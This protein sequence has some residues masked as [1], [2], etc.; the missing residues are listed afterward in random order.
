MTA[1]ILEH[2]ERAA[3]TWN[4]GGKHYDQISRGIADAIEHCVVR[5]N[6]RPGE[7][8]LD[9]STGTGW[10]SR[11]IARHG[12]TV[13]GVD[14]ARDLLTA[15]R[16]KANAERLP[17][18]YQLG[19]AESL[20]FEDASFDIVVSTFGVMFAERPDKA[21]EELARVCRKDGRVALTT[22]LTDGNLSRMFDVLGAYQPASPR[23][24]SPSPFE[25]GRRERIR[26]LLGGTF[27]LRFEKGV[28]YYR[29]PSPEA[30][31]ETFSKGFGPVRSL[32]ASLSPARREA[33][34][35]D[36]IAFHATF[37]SEM[38]ITVP[39]AYWLTIGVR[40]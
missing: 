28:S 1:T 38:G 22:W 30:A 14:I 16:V 8:V 33:L 26:E 20:P 11:V 17:I 10:T 27:D 31:W 6:P 29:E 23:P 35:D 18:K 7:R 24:A 12:A 13:T 39:R 21:A 19:D 32:A 15:A 34:R 37:P 4:A 40:V 36:F 5:L 25:W 9:V 2:N 3:T